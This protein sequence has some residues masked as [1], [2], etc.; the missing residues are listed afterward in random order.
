MNQ[1]EARECAETLEAEFEALGVDYYIQAKKKALSSK[2]IVHVV[3][4]VEIP[5]SR[6]IS[7]SMFQ[8]YLTRVPGVLSKDVKHSLKENPAGI[9]TLTL[10]LHIAMNFTEEQ[11]SRL[12]EEFESRIGDARFIL[13]A[14]NP[15]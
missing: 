3:R 2:W 14:S 5:M 1:Q 7:R 6:N 10:E 15:W 11:L 13:A 12:V 4:F 9:P 8:D